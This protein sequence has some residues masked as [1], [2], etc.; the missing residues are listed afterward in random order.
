MCQSHPR[1]SMNYVQCQPTVRQH[2]KTNAHSPRPNEDSTHNTTPP[3]IFFAMKDPAV[4]APK[5]TIQVN[6]SPLEVLV[7][8]GAS[9][10][11]M[12]FCTFQSLPTRPV[13]QDTSVQ[14]FA[15]AWLPHASANAGTI[16]L[17]TQLPRQ[18]CQ[19]NILC[20]RQVSDSCSKLPDG[21]CP[22]PS[23]PGQ[24]CTCAAQVPH[25]FSRHWKTEG[26]PTENPH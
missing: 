24:E 23:P 4:T 7:D 14:I 5:Q 26:S 2:L 1:Q 16:L 25:H 11:V 8:T 10:N 17:T 18:N 21:S 20:G 12:D 9:V 22:R 6:G 13:L 3:D 15:P 19:K